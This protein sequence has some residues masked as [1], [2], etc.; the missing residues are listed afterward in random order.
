MF[1]FPV[2]FFQKKNKKNIIHSGSAVTPRDKR[3]K[4][5]TKKMGILSLELLLT[6]FIELCSIISNQ[7]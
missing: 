6:V 2:I 1:N 7:N 3:F 4:L 5:E